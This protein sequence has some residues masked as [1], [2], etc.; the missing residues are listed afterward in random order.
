MNG[1]TKEQRSEEHQSD[2]K[3]QQEETLQ[4]RKGLHKMRWTPMFLESK[5]AV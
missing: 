1:G 4:D 3:R 2:T 5:C